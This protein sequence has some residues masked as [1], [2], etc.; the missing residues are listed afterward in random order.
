MRTVFFFVSKV[1]LFACLLLATEA[2]P[3]QPCKPINYGQRVTR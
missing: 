2:K 1:L 3:Q